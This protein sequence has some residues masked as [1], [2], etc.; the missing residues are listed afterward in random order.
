MTPATE[1]FEV[2]DRQGQVLGLATRRECHGNPRL[3]HRVVHVLVRDETERLYLQKRAWTKD[4]QPG[5]WDTSVGGHLH[6]QE[7]PAL[8][9]RRELAEELGIR[10]ERS[11][12]WLYAYE[13][14]SP[15]ETEWVDTFELLWND[16]VFPD[17]TEITEGRWWTVSE[18][19]RHLGTGIFTPN[20]EDEFRR[21]RAQAQES[22]FQ[23]NEK[24]A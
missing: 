10:T 5:K 3:R 16:A 2:I 7:T 8:G 14:C 4:I 13:M 11:L 17:P 1:W 18:I 24:S 22:T 6:P 21:W 9:A 19:R 20:F 12:R 15:V 23:S